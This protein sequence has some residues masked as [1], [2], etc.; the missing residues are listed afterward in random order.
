MSSLGWPQALRA[1]AFRYCAM[2]ALGLALVAGQQPAA[3]AVYT[4][5]QAAAGRDAYQASC[6]ACHL[7]DLRGRNE[8]PALAG[9]NFMSAWGRRSTRELFELMS[10]TMPPGRANLPAE[11]YASILAY[12]LQSN[13]AAAGTQP[14]AAER[15]RRKRP[16]RR[17]RPGGPL[18]R[19]RLKRRRPAAAG[20][21]RRREPVSPLAPDG[22]KGPARV[23]APG[24]ARP[25]RGPRGVTIAGEVKNYV[26]VTDEML[27]N[28]PAGRLA[29]G[30]P[31]L[32]GLELQP[33]DRDHARAT[34]RTCGWRGSWA[35]NDSAGANENMPVVHNGII[36]L[37]QSRATSSRRSTAAP[38]S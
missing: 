32:S 15:R 30:A 22:A 6:A 8:A 14:W 31:Q 21:V 23:E 7:N 16:S 26:T 36:Y 37:V 19:R 35:M 5:E 10:S 9:P 33:A 11:Q 13:G 24:A 29:D 20:E 27:R 2:T 12:L 3:T 38:A 17:W 4:A 25:R 34:S 18:T 28:P 1:G